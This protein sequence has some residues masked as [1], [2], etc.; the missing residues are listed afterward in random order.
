MRLFG[1]IA[2]FQA[3]FKNQ[4]SA[5]GNQFGCGSIFLFSTKIGVA[6]QGGVV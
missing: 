5:I 6:A 4:Q 1:A 2:H 3:H